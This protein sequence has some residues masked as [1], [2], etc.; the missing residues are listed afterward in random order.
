MLLLRCLQCHA[1]KGTQQ[2]T[3]RWILQC[4]MAVHYRVLNGVPQIIHLDD[5]RVALPE[6]NRRYILQ[7][8]ERPCQHYYLMC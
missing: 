4:L 5:V 2:P 1:K 7:F 6:T 3:L 8:F